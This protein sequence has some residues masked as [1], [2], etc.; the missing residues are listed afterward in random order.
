M[1]SGK[2]NQKL[3][4]VLVRSCCGRRGH[5][6]GGALPSPVDLIR[7]SAGSTFQSDPSSDVKRTGIAGSRMRRLRLFGATIF[8]VSIIS[9]A[10]AQI[11]PQFPVSQ[12]D[13]LRKAPVV[14]CE[15]LARS[16]SKTAANRDGCSN[17]QASFRKAFKEGSGGWLVRC[18][19]VNDFWVVVPA[20]AGKGATVLSCPMMQLIMHRDCH[21]IR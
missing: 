9:G 12:S 15:I 17:P 21:M 4:R 18:S 10:Q 6:I 5:P 1:F 20:D 13:L 11:D 2:K 8:Q 3:S 7:A 14:Q 16:I 19:D